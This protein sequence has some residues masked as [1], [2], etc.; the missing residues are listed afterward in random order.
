MR[1]GR[2]PAGRGRNRTA[3]R[4]ADMATAPALSSSTSPMKRDGVAAEDLQLL[5]ARPR[6]GSARWTNSSPPRRSRAKTG[7]GEEHLHHRVGGQPEV[8]FALEQEVLRAWRVQRET[9]V[10]SR[11]GVEVGPGRSPSARR[12]SA[13]P[14]RRGARRARRARVRYP[15]TCRYRRAAARP[16]SEDAGRGGRVVLRPRSTRLWASS[17]TSTAAP[18]PPSAAS[19]SPTVGSKT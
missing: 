7:E 17:T 13:G 8:V 4:V 11:L 10:D 3:A 2:S 12:G 14:R 6:R 9:E 18:S 15:A 16:C 5:A 19:N 1:S